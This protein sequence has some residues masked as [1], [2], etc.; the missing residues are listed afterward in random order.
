TLSARLAPKADCRRLGRE[1]RR[2][3]PVG[4][5]WPCRWC[6][7]L[8]QPATI[9]CDTQ[10][11]PRTTRSSARAAAAWCSCLWLSLRCLDPGEDRECHQTRVRRQ[12]PCRPYWSPA[13]LAG[14]ERPE[15]D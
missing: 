13:A 12:L 2:H 14:L 4:R 8:T 9:G 6:R 5:S 10:T 11:D 15:A 3:Q 7:G 1:C